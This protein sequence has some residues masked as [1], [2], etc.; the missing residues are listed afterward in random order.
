MKVE[1]FSL[2][3]ALLLGGCGASAITTPPFRPEVRKQVP[4]EPVAYREAEEPGVELTAVP[5]PQPTTPTSSEPLAQPSGG[6]RPGG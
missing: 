3:A 1:L 6:A 4:V 5:E 2:L